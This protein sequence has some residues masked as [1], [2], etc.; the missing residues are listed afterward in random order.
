[1]L[2][3]IG[4]HSAAVTL[5][6]IAIVT[7]LIAGVWLSS[8]AYSSNFAALIGTLF[9]AGITVL[10][11][12]WVSEHRAEVERAKLQAILFQ[13]VTQLRRQASIGSQEALTP[14]SARELAR[15]V[16]NRWT[17]LSSFSPYRELGDVTKIRALAELDACC[18]ALAL[19]TVEPKD[20]VAIG[21]QVS[22]LL[23]VRR[24]GGGVREVVK[25]CEEVV[26]RCIEAERVLC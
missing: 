8:G 7:G 17:F 11:A 10:G 20:N 23:A 15:A 16:V 3:S 2:R 21:G 13:G 19:H 26:A 12:V 5:Y 1:M 14:R 22:W 25:E 24:Q 18:R 6:A 4:R 9:G